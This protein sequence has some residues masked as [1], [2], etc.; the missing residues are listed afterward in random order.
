MRLLPRFVWLP[1]W[2]VFVSLSRF[3]TAAFAIG[4]ACVIAVLAAE[5][6]RACWDERLIVWIAALAYDPRV[7]HVVGA[8]PLAASSALAIALPG[9]GTRVWAVRI[10]VLV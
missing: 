7:G 1:P 9:R 10:V 8:L 4:V 5:A 6:R 2:E 3:P